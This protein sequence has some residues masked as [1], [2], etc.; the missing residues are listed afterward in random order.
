[1]LH[2]SYGTQLFWALCLL[3]PRPDRSLDKVERSRVHIETVQA[4]LLL[5]EPAYKTAKHCLRIRTQLQLQ[6]GAA[7]QPWQLFQAAFSADTAQQDA[8]R[9]TKRT[10]GAVVWA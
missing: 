7:D 1:M 9:G 10:E 5:S 6:D 2:S 3:E 8:Q 4:P